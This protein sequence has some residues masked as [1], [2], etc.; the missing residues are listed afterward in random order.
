MTFQLHTFKISKCLVQ[1]TGKYLHRQLAEMF[2][3]IPFGSLL[4]TIHL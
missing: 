3:N 1:N 2:E 4:C